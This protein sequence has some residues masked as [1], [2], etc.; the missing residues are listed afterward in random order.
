MD[1]YIKN[2]VCDRCISAVSQ[3]IIEAK[4]VAKKVIL[5]IA[6]IDGVP[7]N[8][9]MKQLTASLAHLGFAIVADKK[10]QV[11]ET[12]KAAIVQLVHTNYASEWKHIIVS[13]FLRHQTG[14]DYN[15]ISALFSSHEGITI[16]KYLILQKIEK[17]KELISYKELN[18][19]Q[20]AEQMGYSSINALSNQFKKT[21]GLSPSDYKNAPIEA[22]KPIDKIL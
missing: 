13:E 15:Y 1:L 8:G 18:L 19:S 9:Q 22:R 6:S 5:G 14:Y 17:V 4:L 2:M 7:D 21:T 20:I 10:L 11:I 16:E 12:I 3:A